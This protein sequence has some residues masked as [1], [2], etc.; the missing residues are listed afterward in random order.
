MGT[1]TAQSVIGKVFTIL[2]DADKIAWTDAELLAWLN[3][4]QRM[5]ALAR[6]AAAA[7]VGN[8]TTV[9]GTKQTVPAG[10][11]TLLEVV[12]NMGADGATP[13][14]AI[15]PVPRRELDLVD[16]NWHSSTPRDTARHYVFDTR[17]P[18]T[19]YLY[20][21]ATAGRRIEVAYATMPADIPNLASG[22]TLD[23]VYEPVLFHCVLALAFMKDN[24]EA[25]VQRATSHFNVATQLLGNLVNA[26]TA[27]QAQGQQ[28]KEA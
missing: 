23:D 8:I 2:Q 6:P 10:A 20:P 16:L 13:G 26:E 12:R 7:V 4:A 25:N 27:A 24:G 11:H 21:P 19:F 28:P 1:I 17:T 22:I 14:S 5:V 18:R 9:A 15:T 3:Q